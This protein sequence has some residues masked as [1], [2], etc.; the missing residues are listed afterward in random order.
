MRWTVKWTG[1]QVFYKENT[2]LVL[3]TQQRLYR[4]HTGQALPADAAIPIDVDQ[5][6]EE[7][8]NADDDTPPPPGRKLT[9]FYFFQRSLSAEWNGLKQWEKDE[10]EDKAMEWRM[11]G[12]SDEARKA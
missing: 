12:P 3:A 7:D 9:P 2:E 6:E 1:R 5:V 11:G 4:V 10:Y 8:D